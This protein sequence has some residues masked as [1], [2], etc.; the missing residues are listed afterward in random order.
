MAPPRA[1]QSIL[2]SL[3][4]NFHS[5]FFFR[6]LDAFIGLNVLRALSLLSLVLLFCS[7]IVVLARDVNAVNHWIAQGKNNTT[8]TNDM[9][10]CDYIE[11]VLYLGWVG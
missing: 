7:S 1:C 8:A 3:Y 10:D 2:L 6:I 4:L 5:L 9:V 11:Y